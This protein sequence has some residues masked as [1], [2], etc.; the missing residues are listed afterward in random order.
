MHVLI[1]AILVDINEKI[2][3]PASKNKKLVVIRLAE[4]RKR[5]EC[6]QVQRLAEDHHMITRLRI[7]IQ[8]H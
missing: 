4:R 5:H 3:T 6:V 7:A 8:A 1:Y 2:F